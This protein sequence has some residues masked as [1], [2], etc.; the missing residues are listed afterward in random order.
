MRFSIFAFI[1]AAFLATTAVATRVNVE[2]GYFSTI[3]PTP[4]TQPG[5]GCG[6]WAR[7]TADTG[8][9]SGNANSAGSDVSYSQ[10]FIELALR[11]CPLNYPIQS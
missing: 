11:C 2:I 3:V 7:A 8:G 9:V 6:L 5:I 10:N 1:C 4:G